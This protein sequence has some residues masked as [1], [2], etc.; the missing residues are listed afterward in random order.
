M[1]NYLD[2]LDYMRQDYLNRQAKLRM[3]RW[4]SVVLLAT[5]W[6]LWAMAGSN[7]VASNVGTTPYFVAVSGAAGSFEIALP[8]NATVQ[9]PLSSA[10]N[11]GQ[12]LLRY[13]FPSSN[14]I[15]IS[16]YIDEGTTIYLG[17][18]SSAGAFHPF[19]T[20]VAND[21]ASG[22]LGSADTEALN[23]GFYGALVMG[24]GFLIF[25]AIR[26]IRGNGINHGAP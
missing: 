6:A 15:A 21:S 9:F 14:T 13:D 8:P 25:W 18:G 1:K 24:F 26:Q 11:G 2:P 23:Y 10:W 3:I 5:L 19:L 4:L 20:K 12:V 16:D 17:D 22:G 7:V